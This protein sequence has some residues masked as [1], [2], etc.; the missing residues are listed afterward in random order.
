MQPMTFLPI[1]AITRTNRKKLKKNWR[2]GIKKKSK[3]IKK[4]KSCKKYPNADQWLKNK[5]R[6]KRRRKF[7]R[8]KNRREKKGLKEN[9]LNSEHYQSSD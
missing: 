5:S 2:N 6:M 9:S 3:D 7:K 4:Y 8:G 1:M